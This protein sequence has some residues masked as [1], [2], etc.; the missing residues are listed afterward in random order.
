M[1]PT[2]GQHAHYELSNAQKVVLESSA[3]T[4]VGMV[5]SVNEDSVLAQ[6]PVYF[7]ADGMGGH[8]AGDVASRVAI[9]ALSTLVDTT[10]QL[11]VVDVDAA[12]EVAR[13]RVCAIAEQ[14][15]RGA[16]CTLTGV[17]LVEHEG[18][19]CWY[20]VNIGDSRVYEHSGSTLTQVTRDH[21]LRAE[22]YAAG[23]AN[24]AQAPRNVITRAL[25]S[26]DSRHDAWLIPV[27]TGARLLLCS[28][29]LTTELD[30][31]AIRAVLTVGGRPESVADELVR[32][33][34]AAGGRDNVSVVI[35]DTVTGGSANG[36]QSDDAFAATADDTIEVTRPVRV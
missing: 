33:A 2:V 18:Q 19:T 35:V 11:A 3:R 4:H 22:L 5:R 25:G 10:V 36:A 14:T 24:A 29:G 28:D 9:E 13:A 32:L 23:N 26:D 12:I 6:R 17:A 16:G 8:D 31:E 30:D 20:V 1:R 21:S 7:V 15:E 34:C 27:T